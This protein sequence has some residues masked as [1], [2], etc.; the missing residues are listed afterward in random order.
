MSF[1]SAESVADSH[2]F[3]TINWVYN[4]NFFHC[5]TFLL[6]FAFFFWDFS[7]ANSNNKKNQTLL[8]QP[9]NALLNSFSLEKLIDSIAKFHIRKLK[10]GFSVFDWLK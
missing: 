3:K 10:I 4:K 5:N 9:S 6:A 7:R 1:K 8:C 2:L